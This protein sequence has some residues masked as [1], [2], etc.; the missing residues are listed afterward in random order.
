[1]G[2]YMLILCYQLCWLRSNDL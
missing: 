1:M 2:Y